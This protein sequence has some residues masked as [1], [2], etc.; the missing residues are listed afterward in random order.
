MS[1]ATNKNTMRGTAQKGMWVAIAL[2]AILLLLS[3]ILLT[4]RLYDFA[5]SH[6]TDGETV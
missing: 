5:Q 4:V 6:F 2:L 3:L 1:D